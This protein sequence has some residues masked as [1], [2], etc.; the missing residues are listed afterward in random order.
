MNIKV[1]IIIVIFMRNLSKEK[2][3]KSFTLEKSYIF[4]FL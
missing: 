3:G 2:S 1:K 4:P